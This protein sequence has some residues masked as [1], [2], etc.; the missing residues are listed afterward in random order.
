LRSELAHRRQLAADLSALR[1]A[2][3]KLND[4][5]PP[6]KLNVQDRKLLRSFRIA[7]D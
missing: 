7:A 6:F 5:A 3:A 2:A 4:H 1:F